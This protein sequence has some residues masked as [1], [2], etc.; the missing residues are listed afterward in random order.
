MKSFGLNLWIIYLL[1]ALVLIQVSALI[2]LYYFRI[3]K[4]KSKQRNV[5]SVSVKI[6]RP[7]G[8]QAVLSEIARLSAGGDLDEAFVRSLL[9][10]DKALF[11]VALIDALTGLPRELQH[12]LRAT[13]VKHGYNEHCARRL[14]KDEISERVRASTL[15][16]LLHPQSHTLGVESEGT[17]SE[18]QPHKVRSARSGGGFAGPEA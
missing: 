11:E 13:L 12:S 5:N 7:V 16:G 2:L 17:K 8:H 1:G 10:E 15:H 18:H 3:I 6:L 14:M 4:E 9:G